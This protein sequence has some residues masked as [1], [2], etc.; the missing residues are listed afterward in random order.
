MSRRRIAANIGAHIGDKAVVALVQLVTVPVLLHAW[1]TDG[2]GRW[3]M[4]ATLPAFLALG[5]FGIVRVAGARVTALL[6]RGEVAAARVAVHAAWAATLIIVGGL[7]L[8]GTAA[9][10][11]LGEA[12]VPGD[13]APAIGWLALYGVLTIFVRLHTVML[14][15]AGH[16]QLWS[17]SA[18]GFYALDNA[19]L[20]LAA[21]GGADFAQAA[22]AMALSRAAQLLM[23]AITGRRWMAGVMPGLSGAARSEWA[24]LARPALAASV[25]AIGMAAFLQGSTLLLGVLAGA[26]AVPAFVA[27]R[28]LARLGVQ[29]ALVVAQPLGQ[30]FAVARARGDARRSGRL[31]AAVLGGAGLLAIGTGGAL[32]LA[33]GPFIGWWT[34]G[35]I[36]V[37]HALLALMAVST[38]AAVLWSALG[39]LAEATNRQQAL[40]YAHLLA[41]LAGLAVL[42][43]G[44]PLWGALAAAA[45]FALADLLTLAAVLALTVRR[46]LAEPALRAGARSLLAARGGQH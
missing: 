29:A 1:G 46:W 7:A 33:G 3:A 40:A 16:Y 19:A 22:A 38:F 18:T 45:G 14:R 23:V 4:L 44:A 20:L 43:A 8:V 41:G 12:K 21:A 36:E 13:V 32:V 27:V 28:T 10:A 5:D 2:F 25:L 31:L 42:V 11:A 24:V 37:D 9:W 35:R 34:G 15:A 6:A 26:A 30:E 39:Q 17:W